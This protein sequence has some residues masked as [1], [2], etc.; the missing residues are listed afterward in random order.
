MLKKARFALFLSLFLLLCQE[1]FATHLM[2]GEIITRRLPGSGLSF[3]FILSIFTDSSS[4]DGLGIDEPT[5]TLDFGDGSSQTVNRDAP[6]KEYVGNGTYRNTYTFTHTYSGPSTYTVSYQRENRNSGVLNMD[7]S[8]NTPFYIESSVRISPF[9]GLNNSP[10]LTNYP[11]GIGKVGQPFTHNPGAYDPEGDSISYEL[12]IPKQARNINVAG[13]A[14]P[15]IKPIAGGSFSLDPIRGDLIWDAP[16]KAGKYNVAMIIK[17]WRNGQLIGTIVRDMQIEIEDTNNNPPYLILPQDTCIAAGGILNKTIRAIDPDGHPLNLTASSG[18]FSLPSNSAVFTTSN[19]QPSPASGNFFWNT[20]CQLV[21]EQPY[22]VVFRVED[23]P[24]SPPKHFQEKSWMITIKG[25]K[26]SNFIVSP[27]TGGFLLTW[28]PYQCSSASKIEIYRKDCDSSGYIQAPC[29]ETS[30]TS[31]GYQKISE[32][33]ATAVS[34]TDTTNIIPGSFYC[35]FIKASFPLPNGG[36]SYFSDEQCASTNVGE[37]MPTNVSVVDTDSLNGKVLIRWTQPL[38]LDLVTFPGPYRYVVYRSEGV[39]STFFAPI[40]TLFNLTDTIYTDSLIDTFNKIYNYQILFYYDAD[41]LKSSSV[42]ASTVRLEGSPGSGRV[43]LSWSYDVPWNNEGQYHYIYQ[44]NSIGNFILIDSI[45]ATTNPVHYTANGLSNNDTICFYVETSGRYCKDGLAEPLVNKSQIVCEVPR[46]SLPP[47]P[48]ILFGPTDCIEEGVITMTVFWQPDLS[49]GCNTDISG[50]N[51]YYT[52]HEEDDYSLLAANV[53]DTFFVD[54]DNFSLAGCYKVTA[55]NYYG[56]ESPMSNSIC[57]DLCVYYEL[58]NLISPNRDNLNDVF[59]PYPVPKNISQ[60]NFTV[61]NRWGKQVYFSNDDIHLN[62]PGQ[63]DEGKP[64]AS[65]VYF[66]HA[67]VIYKRRLRKED[68][69]R[70]IKG[71]VHVIHKDDEP[72]VE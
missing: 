7:N 43:F 53:P 50:Y 46:D 31:L 37:P 18:V 12:T 65:G 61:Y 67:E 68:Q 48:P 29:D 66:F 17:E 39:N 40:D 33:P 55:L 36:E 10:V 63:D 30:L 2:A 19:P 20:A 34:Y 28:D 4:V 3:Q 56:I 14:H 9:L 1:G 22:L 11:L 62:W 51:V 52:E 32:V 42:P 5:A 64:L 8:G 24:P 26:P 35:Y 15:H 69:V 58:P 45:F 41:E 16:I 38:E 13:Y 72:R 59:K 71:W 25:P 6:G 49:I 57:V 60:V 47:C 54:T 70:H 21:R 27:A 44:K 23:L